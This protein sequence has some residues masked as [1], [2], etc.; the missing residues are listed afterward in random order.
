MDNS[1]QNI[2]WQLLQK[3]MEFIEG[4][5]KNLDDIINKIKNFAFLAWGGSIYLIAE[6]LH[7]LNLHQGWLYLL[8]ALIP[9]LFWA[10]HSRWQEHLLSCA[11]RK[12]VIS[13]FVNESDFEAHMLKDEDEGTDKQFPYYDP[14]GLIYTKNKFSNSRFATKYLVDNKKLN[15]F[16]V[17]FYKDAPLFYG[18]MILL[19]MVFGIV[20]LINK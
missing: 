10:I 18:T 12:K 4:T 14:I 17:V 2:R 20:L 19:S 16:R 6:H 7:N 11:E 1:I 5:V 15:W 9:V 8:T 3:E 13:D